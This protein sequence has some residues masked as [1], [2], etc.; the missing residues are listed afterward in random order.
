PTMHEDAQFAPVVRALRDE[1]IEHYRDRG[2][3]LDTP[4]GLR[5]LDTNST[6]A[7]RRGALLLQVLADRGGATDL[8][9]LRV[10]DPGCGFGAL[11]L[12]FASKGAEVIGVDPN[13]ERSQVA[14]RIAEYLSL[15]AT[16]T[17]GWMDD[18]VLPDASF[19]L[20]VLNNSLC[21]V[22]GRGDRARA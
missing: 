6:L 17:R 15:S 3:R 2:E 13:A 4:A 19:D 5:T 14:S 18:L 10:A 1:I 12:Y 7:A 9:G 21:Y 8:A 11:S 22:V 20:A 16:F